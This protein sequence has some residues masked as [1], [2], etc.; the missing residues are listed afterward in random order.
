MAAGN[1]TY[2]Q[3]MATGE[4]KGN[5]LSAPSSAMDANVVAYITRDP[6]FEVDAD[7]P[8]EAV[9]RYIELDWEFNPEDQFVAHRAHRGD[10]DLR[11]DPD[12]QAGLS[13]GRKGSTRRCL[14]LQPS[15]HPTGSP[16]PT[17]TGLRW[18]ERGTR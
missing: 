11:V 2:G 13:N 8:E 12:D 3:L 16:A 10:A 1:A 4:L 5:R 14:N 18:R 7:T 9:A 17:V 6:R 15:T